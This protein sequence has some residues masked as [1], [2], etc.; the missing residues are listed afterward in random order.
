MEKRD[1]KTASLH[2]PCC[3]PESLTSKYLID[4]RFR[5]STGRAIIKEQLTES[6]D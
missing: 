3:I 5:R 4:L 6:L 2:A 1:K